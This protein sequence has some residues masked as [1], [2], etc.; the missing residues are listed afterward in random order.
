MDEEEA[1]GEGKGRQGGVSYHIEQLFTEQEVGV[2]ARDDGASMIKSAS[3]L[4]HSLS[5]RE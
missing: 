4:E 3:E 2:E 1:G 5:R